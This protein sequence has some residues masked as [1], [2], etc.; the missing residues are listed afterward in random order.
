MENHLTV[1]HLVHKKGTR[2]VLQK[3]ISSLLDLMKDSS[4]ENMTG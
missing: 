2:L 4:L 3:A 1:E